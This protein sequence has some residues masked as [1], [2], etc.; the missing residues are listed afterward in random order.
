MRRASRL[1]E[2]IQILRSARAP[3]T[4]DV[5]ASRLE[6]SRWTV[7]RDIAELISQR[8]PIRSEAGVGYVLE[9]GF[10][11]PPLMLTPDE[12][13]AVTLGAQWVVA[14]AEPG[15]AQAAYAVLGKIALIV[16]DELRAIIDDPAVGTL[17]AVG[18]RPPQTV[19]LARL[20][21]WSREG[22]VLSIR[23]TDEKGVATERT[24]RPF[25]VG[26]VA[27]L[28]VVIAWC[29]TRSD[30]RVFRT[31]RITSVDYVDRRYSPGPAALRRRWAQ[32]RASRSAGGD[33]RS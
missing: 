29:E 31:D 2:I 20:R 18:G 30:F 5:L 15:L 22:R 32:Q 33:D 19:D 26:Y 3:L 14:N 16:P 6:T 23:Y 21:R 4:A 13:E 12:V 27:T 11:L 28:R 17:P 8:V 24:I 9:R 10:D 1:F 25:L 7:Y